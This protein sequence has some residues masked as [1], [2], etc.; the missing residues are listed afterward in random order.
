MSYFDDI[1][2][3]LAER[4][5][6]FTSTT[7]SRSADDLFPGERCVIA[8]ACESRRRE[9][10]TGRWCARRLLAEMGVAGNEIGRGGNNE[11]VWPKGICGSITHT[12]GACCVI[13]SFLTQYSSVGIDIE[14]ASRQISEPARRM[15]LNKDEN[16][17]ID[18]R[19][20]ISENVYLTI[21]SIKESIYKMLFPLVKKTIPFSTASV[22][23]LTDDGCFSYTIN[24]D[25]TETIVAGRILNG[26]MF[27]SQTWILTVAALP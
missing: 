12:K 23:S 24:R 3:N 16:D 13:A 26:W 17:W 18:A 9:F 15:F 5:I 1:R 10:A 22:Q 8:A 2:K 19:P 27:R 21:F 7:E 14:Q 25:L 20:R 4:S 6:F 11:P